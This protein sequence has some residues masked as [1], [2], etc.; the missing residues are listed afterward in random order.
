MGSQEDPP[1]TPRL[2]SKQVLDP[3]EP[4]ELTAFLPTLEF[5]GRQ[6]PS[7]KTFG[8]KGAQ[9]LQRKNAVCSNSGSILR[10]PDLRTRTTFGS[11][12]EAR[13]GQPPK[14]GPQGGMAKSRGRLYL[15]M[16]LAAVLASFLAGFMVGW[17]IK[18]FKE[19]TTS[20]G[21]HQSM[22][23]N[24]VSEMKAENIKSFLRSFTKLPHLAGTEQNLLLAKKIQTQWK[25]FGLD[26][27]EL[28]HYDVLLSYPNETNAN[29]ISIMDEH[30]IEI[31]N[32]SYLEPPPDGYEN[33]TNIVPPYNAFSAQGMPEGDLIYVNYARTED[34]FKLEREM[35]INC[36]GKIVIA[37]Y[38]KIFRGNKVKNAMSAGAIGIILYSDPADYFAPGVQPYPKGWNLPG[39]AVQRGNVLNLNG[40]GDPLT[41]GYPA[42]EYTFRLDVKEGVGIPKIPV[43]PIGYNDA[44]VLLRHMGGT[45]PP[46]DSWKGSLN[47]DYNIGPGFAGHDSFRKVRMHVHNT[48]K[49]TRIYNV[50]GTIRGS[51]EPD[52]YV[53]LG[54]H[55]DSWVF[56]AIDPTSG[57]AVLQEIVQSF[58]KL[59]DRGWRPRRTIIFA[60]WDAEEFGL[61]G[62]TEWAEE[63]AKTLQ[64]R[65]I[66]YINSDSSIEGNYTLRVD[67]TPL[68]YQ[69]VYKLTKEISS[70]DDGFESKSLYE[71]WLEK[72][73]SSENKDFPR[74]NKLGSGSDFEAYFQR[75]GIASGRARYTKNRKTDKYSSYPVYHTIYETFELVENF[76]D[77]TFKKQL[78]VAQLR[79]ALV[80]ELA[81]SKII[82]FNI[83]DY[84]KA[85]KNYATSIYNLSKKHDQR[86][87]DHGVSFDSLFSA[88]KN[89]SDAASDFH[90]RLTEVDLNNPIAVRIMNDQ[91]M[92]LE[93]AFIDPLGLPGRRFYRHIIFA[94]S[95]H[96]KYAG[97]SFPG[98]YD[99]MFDI[100]NK[101]DPQSA[102]TEV[103]K[104]ISI[105]AFTIQAAAGTLK[106]V[107]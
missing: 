33:V 31:F 67:C 6:H 79:G 44:E 70:P 19:S 105:A 38:G 80:Y 100:E 3:K 47:V 17:F 75:L 69:L 103:K 87:R 86:L 57:A 66:A 71:S 24:L 77:P 72:D 10:V 25:K 27:A 36:S 89:F 99:A 60:S 64:E 42:K 1:I 90:R 96:N 94:P 48:N 35:N 20:L 2:V 40:A 9:S 29:Y 82:P 45:A 49:I 21:Y 92:L 58:G 41:P 84:A 15:W 76:Y 5:E 65:S 106:E 46:D 50:I 59:M 91:L 12:L 4:V 78:S 73:P 74:I 26:S 16:C 85:L 102:W 83:E 18:P 93:R 37:R 28:V 62:S 81:D 8:L 7:V 51:V 52:R 107:L 54:G 98:I 101:E 53:I 30:G 39:T 61:L 95:S 13:S 22:R 55:R 43:H 68:L 63:N 11:R 32:T 56:G 23:W 104:H 14:L 97:E 88:V 34:F